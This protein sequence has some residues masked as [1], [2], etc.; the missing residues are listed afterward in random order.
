MTEWDIKKNDLKSAP[1]ENEEEE[2][3]DEVG[4]HDVDPHVQGQRVHEREQLRRLLLRLSTNNSDKE[5]FFQTHTYYWRCFLLWLW[6]VKN[7]DSQGH[8]GV[9]KVHCLLPLI[10][11]W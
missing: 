2:G 6:P 5:Y 10:G 9:G 8:E 4:D 1:G 11:D 7:A 3:D